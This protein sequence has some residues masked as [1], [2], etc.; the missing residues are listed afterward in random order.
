MIRENC[1]K[2]FSERPKDKKPRAA[3]I[4]PIIWFSALLAINCYGKSTM[5][6]E[7]I[8]GTSTAEIKPYLAGKNAVTVV[9]GMRI[10]S[11]AALTIGDGSVITVLCKPFTELKA[12]KKGDKIN[13][14][15]PNKLRP[16]ITRADNENKAPILLFP[17]QETVSSLSKIIWGTQN[18][19]INEYRLTIHSDKKNTLIHEVYFKNLHSKRKTFHKHQYTIPSDIQ[20]SFQ[21]GKPYRIEISEVK[22]DTKGYSSLSDTAFNGVITVKKRNE[23]KAQ[24]KIKS[25][26]KQKAINSYFTAIRLIHKE[27]F[28]EA[29][30][31]LEKATSTP[32]QFIQQQKTNLLIQQSIPV[33]YRVY[34]LYDTIVASIRNNDKLTANDACQEISYLFSSLSVFWQQELKRISGPDFEKFPSYCPH[35]RASN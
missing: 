21:N 3:A 25:G 26:N 19:D 17:R 32:A 11:D 10:S 34:E 31:N 28:S 2:H 30:K 13:S 1:T 7:S 15:C 24:N 18:N 33:D 23:C 20:K 4:R 12:I 16:N 29:L 5:Y 6:V 22:K 8:S 9:P 14:I 27:C 35:I